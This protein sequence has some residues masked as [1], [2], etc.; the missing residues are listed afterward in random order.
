MAQDVK[1]L[2]QALPRRGVGLFGPEERGQALAAMG[3]VGLDEEICQE[4][5][6]FIRLKADHALVAAGDPKWAEEVIP[7]LWHVRAS[8][9]AG[10]RPEVIILCARAPRNALAGMGRRPVRGNPSRAPGGGGAGP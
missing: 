4:R 3:V 7:Q 2:A 10:S 9:N 6:H 8:D 1:R 5:A